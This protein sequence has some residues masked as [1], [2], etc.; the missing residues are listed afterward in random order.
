V[1]LIPLVWA[2][3]TALPMLVFAHLFGGAAWASLEYS[4][5]QLQLSSSGPDVAAEFFSISNA[6]AG[7]AA[8]SGALAGG[9]LLQSGL[10]GYDG[11][12]L[13]SGALR[14]VPLALL[15]LAFRPRDF[16]TRLGAVYTRV[17]SVRPA[18][19]A[20]QRPIL[21]SAASTE[22]ASPEAAPGAS[23]SADQTRSGAR[24]ATP[25]EAK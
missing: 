22:A 6:L 20:T 12:F 19:G 3:S 13:L 16:P 4:S 23:A 18:A 21:M 11:V 2:T 25:A 9:Y 5:F 10:I 14:A 17:L 15:A 24:S 8:I 7:A 1:A